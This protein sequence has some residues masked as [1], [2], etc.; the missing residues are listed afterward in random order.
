MD[1]IVDEIDIVVCSIS[2]KSVDFISSWIEETAGC[3]EVAEDLGLAR[4]DSNLGVAKDDVVL[5]VYHT[6]GN[7]VVH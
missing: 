7:S 2:E 1:L 3:A 5:I 4:T 6:F